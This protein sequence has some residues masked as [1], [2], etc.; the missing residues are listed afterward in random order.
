MNLYF[1]SLTLHDKGVGFEELFRQI[2]TS[3]ASGSTTTLKS[4]LIRLF[5]SVKRLNR[6]FLLNYKKDAADVTYKSSG[7]DLM[8]LRLFYAAVF[9]PNISPDISEALVLGASQLL[10]DPTTRLP[11]I[12][13]QLRFFIILL[14]NPALMNP[15]YHNRFLKPLCAKLVCIERSL[16]QYILNWLCEYRSSDCGRENFKRMVSAIQQFITFRVYSDIDIYHDHGIISAVK[17]L[18]YFNMANNKAQLVPFSAFYNQAINETLSAETDFKYWIRRTANFC[19]C[20]YPYILNI[21]NKNRVMKREALSQMT[22]EVQGVVMNAMLRGV[23]QHP[24]LK[25]QVRRDHIIQDTIEQLNRKSTELKKQLRVTFL[26][27][28]GID[29]GGL[30]KEYF[31]LIVREIFDPNYGMFTF[32]KSSNLFWFSLASFESVEQFAMVGTI[33]GLAIYNGIILDLHFP[34]VV[35][36]KLLKYSHSFD[37]LYEVDPDLAKGLRQLLDYQGDDLEDIYDSTFEITKEVF[38]KRISYNLKPGGDK[39]MLTSANRREY[40]SLYVDFMLNKSVQKQF[41]AFSRGFHSVCG[42]NSLSLLKPEELELLICGNPSLD[43]YQVEKNAIYQGYSAQSQTIRHFW[44]IAHSW[45]IEMRKKLLFF[46]TGSDRIPFKG[47]GE[48][49]LKFT[50]LNQS[51]RLP[52]SHTCFNQI[53][54]PDYQNKLFLED[55]LSVAIENAEGFGLR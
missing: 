28:E 34:F 4:T 8:R 48:L 30:Q 16:G 52:V 11:A 13:E 29:A 17:V 15:K 44:S 43:L 9:S 37:D 20:Q 38:G 41:E 21:A 36:K 49:K 22:R 35:Y 10:A 31:Q 55:R 7:V 5:A 6:S 51:Q 54:L 2:Q 40:V 23:R 1:A 32:D 50:R 14:E 25:L 42:G 47:V 39:V 24:H 27:E 45:P 53:L 26:G 19:Y 3:L 18:G 12:P 33:L 46:I